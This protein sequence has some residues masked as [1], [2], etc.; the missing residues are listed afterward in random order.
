[1]FYS[2][3]KLFIVT[4]AYLSFNTD[5][6]QHSSFILLYDYAT[7]IVELSVWWHA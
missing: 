4:N 5:V 2:A 1:M 7:I 6:G 3:Y